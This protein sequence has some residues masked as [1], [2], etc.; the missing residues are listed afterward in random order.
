MAVEVAGHAAVGF[1]FTLFLCVWGLEKRKY[2]RDLF[3]WK[4]KLP[5][6]KNNPAYTLEFQKNQSPL[7]PLTSL[8]A[9][10]K[11]MALD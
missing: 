2:I 5:K 8:D 7:S 6:A 10:L 11:E 9:I 1:Q 4:T 3:M